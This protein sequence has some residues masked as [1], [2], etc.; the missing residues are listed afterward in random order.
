M[1]KLSKVFTFEFIKKCLNKTILNSFY[2]PVGRMGF[3]SFEI[4]ATAISFSNR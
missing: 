1:I 3:I 2:Y 4:N